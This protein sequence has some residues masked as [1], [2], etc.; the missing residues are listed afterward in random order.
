[1][2]MQSLDNLQL[3]LST[4]KKTVIT[5]H[6]KPDADALGSSLGW[7]GYLRK[8]GHDVTVITPSDY[9]RFLNWMAGEK[10]VLDYGNYQQKAEADRKI[11][12][13]E[14]IFCLDFNSLSRIHSM[15]PAVKASKSVKVM[16]DHHLNPDSF[17]SIMFSEP[18]AAATAQL[19]YRI[20][21]ELGGKD[22]IDKDI[23]SALYAGIMTDT[24]SFKYDS[25]SP[26]VYRIAADIKELGVDTTRIHRL[27]FDNT[28][29]D[30]LRLLGY[31]LSQKMKLVPEYHTA[32]ITL[33][34]E[35]LKQFNSQT[36]DTEGLVN[37]ALSI[38]GVVMA[39]LI[40]DRTEM[41]KLSFRSI[42]EFPVNELASS[43]F[44]GG[45]HRNAAGGKASLSLEEV[46]KKFLS[47][48]PLYK[49]QIENNLLS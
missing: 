40:I 25:T 4:P 15:E 7:A 32:Y 23:A 16:I 29:Y 30:R 18:K 8:L 3:L 45:G 37:Y 36:G 21:V 42:N 47:L 10:D 43:H 48:L 28:T 11:A 17:A 27:V 13:A 31:V 19:I 22:L 12:E 41:I 49:T 34:K 44:E 6:H 1:M 46:E 38:E 2:L 39:A 5:T 33:T 14:V 26:E 24:G 20:I 9:P 35:E